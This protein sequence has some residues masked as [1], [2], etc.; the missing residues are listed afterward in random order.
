[1]ESK[2]LNKPTLIETAIEDYDLITIDCDNALP[3]EIWS[4]GKAK[5]D[6][7]RIY[8][9]ITEKERREIVYDTLAYGKTPLLYRLFRLLILS[10][11]KRLY[12]KQGEPSGPRSN[13]GGETEPSGN[14][15]NRT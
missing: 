15:L 7:R 5:G 2:R 14:A 13:S 1:M 3:V 6:E 8:R 11:T 9:P 10:M 4:L 12:P